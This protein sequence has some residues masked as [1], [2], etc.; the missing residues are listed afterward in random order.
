MLLHKVSFL[1]R[2]S[3]LRQPATNT[4]TDIEAPGTA[5]FKAAEPQAAFDAVAQEPPVMAPA[6]P[7]GTLQPPRRRAPAP[8]AVRERIVLLS[9]AFVATALTSMLHIQF[10]FTLLMSMAASAVFTVLSLLMHQLSLRAAEVSR[11]KR[12]LARATRDAHDVN[13]VEQPAHGFDPEAEDGGR[14]NAPADA[15]TATAFDKATS[16]TGTAAP[17]ARPEAG[18]SEP[19]S[20]MWSFRPRDVAALGPDQ[21][22]GA[23]PV[24][25]IETDLELVQRKIRE[26]ADEVNGQ[27]GRETSAG[28]GHPSGLR[29]NSDRILKPAPSS[30][31]AV[32]TEP[33]GG[34]HAQTA[35]DTARDLERSIDALRNAASEMRINGHQNAP[36]AAAKR[37]APGADAV[38]PA[39]ALGV[40]VG[41]A[42]DVPLSAQPIATGR[43]Q[44]ADPFQIPPSAQRIAALA[45]ATAGPQPE[46]VRPVLPAA[47]QASSETPASVLPPLEIPASAASVAVMPQRQPAAS[48]EP[49]RTLDDDPFDF[50]GAIAAVLP[51][52]PNPRLDAIARSI[53]DGRMEVTLSPIVGLDSHAVGHYGVEFRLTSPDGDVLDG[54]EDE[55]VLAGGELL[56]LF[57]QARLLRAATL[58]NQLADR[59]KLGSLL[60]NVAG[61]SL[62]EG[63]FLGTLGDIFSDRPSISERL[64]LTFSQYDI[65]RFSQSEWQALADMHA[66]GFRFAIAD[67]TK[68]GFLFARL[69]AE[70]LLDGVPGPAGITPAHQLC[71][72]LA[73]AGMTVIAAGIKD[74]AM[75]ARLFGFGV[76]FGQGQLFGA[77]RKIAVAPWQPPKTDGNG[78]RGHSA[79]A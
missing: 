37:P 58:A 21:V 4:A 59:A 38:R 75:R 56:A 24:L 69:T 33:A 63:P 61:P 71:S 35:S 5:E 13:S 14:Q 9:I 55:I 65:G 2:V 32:A 27:T 34:D 40:D 41:G 10:G 78:R 64:V 53:R 30:V 68:F 17:G 42:F 51:P 74:D 48:A 25:P 47:P 11:L 16:L 1:R 46:A 77:P 76:L 43:P 7:P 3:D 45:A 72:Q 67:I 6:V 73:G 70:Q 49:S 15:A 22:A 20:E 54:A 62:S 19:H 23:A 28:Y 44:T 50:A 39:D 52:P 79:A 8:S 60:S 29:D 57:D 66:F 26:L 31:E 12:E 36:A 18:T